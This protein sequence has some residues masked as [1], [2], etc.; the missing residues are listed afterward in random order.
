MEKIKTVN[1]ESLIRELAILWQEGVNYVDI[2]GIP[3]QKE[4]E[5]DSIVLSFNRNYIDPEK[6]EKFENIFKNQENQ[7]EQTL[8]I[9]S[10]NIDDL[11]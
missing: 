6:I 11:I 8:K 3:S 10:K 7:E 1:V 4:D 2:S 9:T 5:S